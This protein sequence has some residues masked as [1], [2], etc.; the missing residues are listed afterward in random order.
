MTD[1]A[2]AERPN[3]V[4]RYA[5][6]IVAVAL[7]AGVSAPVNEFK[8]PPL[9]PVLMKTFQLD[10]TS[11]GLLMSVFAVTGLMLALPAGL[12][13]QKLGPKP[14][15]LAAVGLLIAGSAGGALAPGAGLLLA[16]RLFEGAGMGLIAVVA[17][18]T[19]AAWFPAEK[20]GRPMGIWAT[21][22][23]LGS[24]IAFN[25]APALAM[26]AGWRAVW[27]AGAAFGLIAFVLYWAFIRIPPAVETKPGRVEDART[28]WQSALANRDIWLLALSFGCF[29]FVAIGVNTTFFPTFLTA[30]REYSLA[31][32]SF[33]ASLKQPA[34]IVVAPLAGW[35]SDRIGSRR[36]LLVCGMIATGVSMTFMFSVSGWMI[37]ASM[38]V[39][40][41]I[42]GAVVAAAFSSAPE[43]MG[44][45]KLAGIGVA[46]LMLGQNLG[47][48]L[49]PV[50][51]GRLVQTTGWVTAGY[52]TIP[53][54]A[55]GIWAAWRTKMR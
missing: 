32:A 42:S 27:W 7:L 49:G 6:V 21:W 19:I 34:V 40:G 44:K 33:V 4:P 31:G 38:V 22:V 29:N 13:L 16:S 10:L 2:H 17:P 45:P 36:I 18:A 48:L 8:A 25:T 9:M 37:P 52:C 50:C 39:F 47:Q 54:V 20:R 30:A 46:I 24:L 14:A 55:L 35:L 41:V 26:A 15:G 51:F 43:V 11:A 3:A 12:I 53:V 5:W 1:R 28:P 23:P